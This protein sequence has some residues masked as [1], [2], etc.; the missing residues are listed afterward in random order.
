MTIGL[1]TSVIVASV[2]A[3]HP[4]HGP[5]AKW[6]NQAFDEHDLMITHHTVLESYSVL[7]RLPAKYLLSPTEAQLVLRETL[8]ETTTIAR[9]QEAM[10]WDIIDRFVEIPAVG[11]AAYD[12]FSIEILV[13]AGVEAIATYNVADFKRLSSVVQII[14]P[15]A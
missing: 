7:T 13:A 1:D 10:V 15:I 3:N 6:L 8:S 9:F 14:N 2:H 5:T 11:G 12:A 4:F